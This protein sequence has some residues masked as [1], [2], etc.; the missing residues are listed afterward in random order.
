MN[1]LFTPIVVGLLVGNLPYTWSIPTM[2]HCMLPSGS[3]YWAVSS[4]YHDRQNSERLRQPIESQ[5]TGLSQSCR[6]CLLVIGRQSAEQNDIVRLLRR[7]H[8]RVMPV[9]FPYAKSPLTDRA[10]LCFITTQLADIDECL[11]HFRLEI[12]S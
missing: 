5:A 3:P 6:Y 8:E 9:Y 4:P 2:R 7:L 11:S 1:L 12:A 10:H